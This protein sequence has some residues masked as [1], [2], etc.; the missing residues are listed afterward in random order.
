MTAKHPQAPER[1]MTAKEVATVLGVP[2]KSVYVLS[3]TPGFPSGIRITP[4]RLRWRLSQIEE[5]IAF[6]DHMS[7]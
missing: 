5:W 1:L 4:Q 2:V 7:S 3:R 6:R